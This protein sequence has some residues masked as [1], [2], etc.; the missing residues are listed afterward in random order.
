M[1][2]LGT[3]PLEEGLAYRRELYVTIHNNH[4]RR[5]SMSPAGF[6]YAIPAGEQPK[7]YA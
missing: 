4:K 1:H 6:E 2:T 3:A 5:K 7:T